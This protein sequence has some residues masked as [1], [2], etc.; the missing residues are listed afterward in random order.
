MHRLMRI[1]IKPVSFIV[2]LGLAIA[3]KW[4]HVQGSQ[5]SG[6]ETITIP[7]AVH[8]LI[9][10]NRALSSQ[11]TIDSIDNHF[12]AV[13]RIWSQADI[14]FQ[15]AIM[16]QVSTPN[17]ILLGLSHRRGRGGLADF[18]RSIRS[19]RI[20]LGSPHEQKI[21]AFY[22]RSLG[23]PN[24]LKPIGRSALFVADKTTVYDARVTSHEIGHNLGLFH[25]R[26]DTSRL[27][28]SGSNG[29]KL[30]EEEQIVARYNAY[31]LLST[32]PCFKVCT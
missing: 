31:Q 14:L 13:N 3:L 6:R 29:V 30:T 21:Q 27:L 17:H 20:D 24:G 7:V 22:V 8:I 1:L 9:S 11:R 4:S 28:F 12:A 25:V 10:D 5:E 15:P 18:F 16:H 32:G 26:D 19:G 23:G 2:I